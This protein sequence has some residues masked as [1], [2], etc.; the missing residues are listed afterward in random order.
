[1]VIIGIDPGL[2]YTGWGAIGVEA[3]SCVHI[4][5]GVVVIPSALSVPERLAFLFGSLTDIFSQYRPKQSVVE[6]A[7]FGKNADSAF[8][9]GLARGV[10]LTVSAK[11]NCEVQ[12]YAAREI[13]KGI[14]GSGSSE[15][16]TV[17]LFVSRILKLEKF[18]RSDAS[19]ALALALY[20]AW[21]IDKKKFMG[22]RGIEA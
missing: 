19:D 10:A 12:E 9:L 16:D 8:K 22:I 20:G 3:G 15:K 18:V 5:N 6:K 14:T 4:A 2:Q 7:F 21:M 17:A 13:K 11:A 1:M